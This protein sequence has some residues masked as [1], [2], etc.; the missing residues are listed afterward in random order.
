MLVAVAED[1]FQLQLV[2]VD[3]VAVEQVVT[4]V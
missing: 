3:P 2:V 4:Q 1:Q